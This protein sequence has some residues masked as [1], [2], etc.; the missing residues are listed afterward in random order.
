ML[1]YLSMVGPAREFML[2]LW[3]LIQVFDDIEDGGE[4]DTFEVDR[5]LWAALVNFPTNEFYVANRHAISGVMATQ[6]L[7]WK[8]ATQAENKGQADERSYMWRAGYF[9]IL[10]YVYALLYGRIAA[11]E[12]AQDIMSRY[13]ET[14]EFYAAEFIPGNDQE[15]TDAA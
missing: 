9:D 10:M 15:K 12:R 13:N 3:V 11:Q 14:F 8:A 7:K 1:D 6:I 2:D 5:A 4:C